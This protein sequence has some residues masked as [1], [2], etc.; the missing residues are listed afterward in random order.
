[1]IIPADVGVAD[2]CR[3]S[4]LMRGVQSQMALGNTVCLG[5]GR[6]GQ[7]TQRSGTAP[8]GRLGAPG[9]VLVGSGEDGHADQH[10]HEEHHRRRTRQ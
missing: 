4:T 1:M 3:R 9:Q 5:L 2:C 6:G 10:R 7:V 8:S